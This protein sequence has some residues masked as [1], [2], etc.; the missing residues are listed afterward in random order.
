VVLRIIPRL[1]RGKLHAYKWDPHSRRCGGGPTITMVPNL[2]RELFG[3]EVLLWP[4][5]HRGNWGRKFQAATQAECGGLSA[6]GILSAQPEPQP[7]NYQLYCRYQK[8]S[9]LTMTTPA[10]TK[11]WGN[12]GIA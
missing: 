2:A 9:S 1:L 7:G 5:A 6:A 10:V 8:A 11:G 12:L 3:K 4:R